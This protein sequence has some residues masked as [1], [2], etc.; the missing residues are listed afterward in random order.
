[1]LIIR[2]TAPFVQVRFI[3]QRKSKNFSDIYRKYLFVFT[4]EGY[5][6]VLEMIFV[7]KRLIFLLF[8]KKHIP[9]RS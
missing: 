4:L 8:Q 6:S 9:L 5:K 7:N 1:M 2:A 3:H